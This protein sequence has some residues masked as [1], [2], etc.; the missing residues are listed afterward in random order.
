[1]EMDNIVVDSVC[2]VIHNV[3]SVVLVQLH[4]EITVLQGLSCANFDIYLVALLSLHVSV[5][6]EDFCFV[7][8]VLTVEFLA[9]LQG[10]G[11]Q[12]ITLSFIVEV[13]EDAPAWMWV[14]SF[15]L[16]SKRLITLYLL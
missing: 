5:G 9:L 4:L 10:T 16:Q 6:D 1:M 2:L 15:I 11:R 7:V 12:I 13:S 8:F 3:K 14:I